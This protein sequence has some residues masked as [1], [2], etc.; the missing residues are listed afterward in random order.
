MG[1]GGCRLGE[2]GPEVED[3]AG[4]HGEDGRTG[5]KKRCVCGGHVRQHELLALNVPPK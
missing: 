2:G 4:N 5:D 1:V 3:D